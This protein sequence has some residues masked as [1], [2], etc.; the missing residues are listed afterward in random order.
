MAFA[1]TDRTVLSDR[2]V[3]T[4]V[5]APEIARR[6]RAGQF[7]MV[8]IDDHGERIPLTIVDSDPDLGTITLVY[9]I[10][11]RTTADLAAM[12]PGE[13]LAHVLGPLGRPTDVEGVANA[14]CVGGGVGIG[15]LYPIAVALAARGARVTSVLGAR[16]ADLLVLEAETR[17]VCDVVR[18]TTDD[19]SAGERGLV[20]GVLAEIIASGQPV[21]RVFAIG[22]V[23]MMRAVAE[24][25]R[26]AAIPTTVSLNP[27]MV[28]GT[29]MC[30]GCRVRVG[31]VTR[32][33]CV[34]GP[35]FDGHAVDFD[36][37]ASRLRTYAP[38][39]RAA[40]ER[41]GCRARA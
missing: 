10:V 9:Q 39:E 26:A 34:D 24:V 27:I 8:M 21:D 28:D 35:E 19:G 15:V 2:V 22:P 30:G 17:A 37:L 14:V 36:Q 1:I 20:T 23:P 38:Q 25:T 6:R 41:E 18:V 40:M 33:A 4:L 7:V 16:S 29:G 32:F 13:S 5:E 31:G 11:G 12:R 3:R